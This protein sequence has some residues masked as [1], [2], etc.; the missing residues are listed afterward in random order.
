MEAG[1]VYAVLVELIDR[2]QGDAGFDGGGDV[3][4]YFLPLAVSCSI[5]EMVSLYRS[6]ASL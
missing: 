4:R 1:V 3:L 5:C 2:F 6:D